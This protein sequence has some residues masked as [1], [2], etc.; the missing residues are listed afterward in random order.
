MNN[1]TNESK[2]ESIT[3]KNAIDNMRNNQ[4]SI[5]VKYGLSSE[6]FEDMVRLLDRE[7]IFSSVDNH[8]EFIRKDLTKGYEKG[9]VEIVSNLFGKIL[10]NVRGSNE[11]GPI[12]LIE[13]DNC[14]DF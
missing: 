7:D 1:N 9:N 6:Q 4:A 3:H 11:V 12:D 14:S 8:P 10:D 13:D 5:M 2:S